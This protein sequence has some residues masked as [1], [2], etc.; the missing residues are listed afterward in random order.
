MQPFIKTGYLFFHSLKISFRLCGCNLSD[1][2]CRTLVPDLI[3]ENSFLRELD[4][5]D[6]DLLD[7]GVKILSQGLRNPKCKLEVL[8]SVLENKKIM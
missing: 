6:N 8:R 5:S 1:R 7:E 4:L 3:S 2:S